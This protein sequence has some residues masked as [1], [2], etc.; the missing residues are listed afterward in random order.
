M[1]EGCMALDCTGQL[2]G[3]Q[4]TQHDARRWGVLEEDAQRDGQVRAVPDRHG[5]LHHSRGLLP[6][7]AMTLNRRVSKCCGA[8]KVPWASHRED[9]SLQGRQRRFAQQARNAIRTGACG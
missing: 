7:P 9:V 2:C 6:S 4:R 5:E 1:L 8:A 3:P